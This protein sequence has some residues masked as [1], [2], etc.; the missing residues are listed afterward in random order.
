LQALVA[1]ILAELVVLSQS[2]IP[3][4]DARSIRG[5]EL[6]CAARETQDLVFRANSLGGPKSIA[7]LVGHLA[8][9]QSGGSFPSLVDTSAA[10]MRMRA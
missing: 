5:Q 7:K 8:H 1:N 9:R 3:H 4:A 10:L 2:C 6:L